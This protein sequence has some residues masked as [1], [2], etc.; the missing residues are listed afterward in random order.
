MANNYKFSCRSGVATL[1]IFD[2]IDRFG[3]IGAR[4]IARDVDAAGDVTTLQVRVNSEGGDILEAIG[5]YNILKSHPARV[6]MFVDGMALSAA[7]LVVMAGDHIE[8]AANARMMIHNPMG[9]TVSAESDEHRSMAELLDSLRE[10]VAQTHAD[11]TGQSLETILQLMD[12]ETW[13]TASEAI[14]LG[15]ADAEG[16]AL[17]V[18]AHVKTRQYRNIPKEM[19]STE[20]EADMAEHENQ[21]TGPVVA[22][23]DELENALPGADNDFLVAQ[24]K[25]K[26]TLPQAQSAWMT[27]QSRRIEAA[28]KKAVSAQ[29]AAEAAE[30]AK[31]E[32]EA[33]PG[34]EAMNEGKVGESENTAFGG[35]PIAEWKTRLQAKI[36]AGMPRQQAASRLNKEEPGLREAM[37]EAHNL[38]RMA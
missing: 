15:F 13:L 32:A 1:Y 38:A 18:A 8:I 24:M 9:T 2:V 17:K 28:E 35:D 29:K 4:D 10:S 34:V 36:D 25:A 14:E 12:E 16:K 6:E 19:I 31:A 23:F 11:R 5:I 26:A 21:V 20:K 27:E 33:K 37:V 22:S 3:G 30:K 7:A